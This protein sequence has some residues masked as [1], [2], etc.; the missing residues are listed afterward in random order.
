L[1][2]AATA[3]VFSLNSATPEP[4]IITATPP[5]T[6][7]PA[8]D[9]GVDGP[10]V[11]TATPPPVSTLAPLAT[12]DLPPNDAIARAQQALFNGNYTVAV[13]QYQA[14]LNQ[15]DT[16]L[17][18]SAWYG[19][20]QAALREGLFDQA[21]YAFTQFIET[22]PLEARIPQAYFQRGDAYLG[23]GNWPAAIADFELYLQLHPGIIDSYAYERMAD[24]Y[25]ALGWPDQAF[26]YYVQAANAPRNLEPMVA[27]RERIATAYL[28]QGFYAEAL[29][30][31]DS[32]LSV[33]Q[34]NGYRASIEYQAALIEFDLALANQ[35][36][37]RLN[38]IVTTYP[39]TAAAYQAMWVLLNNNLPVDNLLRAKISFANEDYGDV[40][41]ALN[42]YSAEVPVM[43]AEHLLTLGQAYRALGN[44]DAA[45]ITFQTIVD[46]YATS[47]MFGQALLEIGRTYFWQGDY[48]NA[49]NHYSSIATTYPDLPE[50]AEALWRVGFIYVNHFGDVDRA[51]GTYDILGK[52]YPGNEWAVDGLLSGA[53]LALNNDKLQQA[54]VFYTQ[55]ANTTVSGEEKALAFFWLARLYE[56]QGNIE[57]ATTTFQGASQADPGSYYSL[58][59]T[60]IL[61]GEA[62]FTPPTQ[63]RFSFDEG[64]VLA[65]AERW[66][67]ATF[68]IKQD[69][70]LYPLS[71]GLKA[72][73]HIIRG[74]ELWEVGAFDDARGEYAQL[75]E[76]YEADP[77]AIYQLAHY[78]S[79]KG[80]YRLSIEAAAQLI[81]ASGQN[82]FDV[83]SYIARLRYPV[84]YK[85]LVLT[86]SEQYN[87]DP[88]LIF[89]LIRQ[90]SLYQSFA[91]SFAYA[92]GLM[93]IIPDTG[94]W[95]AQ[96]LQWPNYQNSDLY[97]PYV[98]VAFGTFYLDWVLGVVDNYP[99][100]ALAGYNG[101]P[102]N[103]QH[104]LEIS[105]PDIDRFVQTIDFEETQLYVT[106]I[107]EQYNIY[108]H[109]YGLN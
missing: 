28:N 27:L 108:R 97:R 102:G 8:P 98:N 13:S 48:V 83:P 24:A 70:L 80:V 77:L 76:I 72:D 100:A 22:F 40:V 82:T 14:V 36:F 29:A 65:E 9:V 71:A 11:I 63:Y 31:Y 21:V 16:R 20:A 42:N 69:G 34:N 74:D 56:A 58:R 66:L 99:Y 61:A 39:E 54:Q 79:Q 68:A 15:S 104:W 1:G 86:Y 89:A 30:Q 88:L 64:T 49:I 12:P 35:A 46:Q 107:Y 33:A 105:G 3:C 92:Q 75:L 23:L 93:Q 59:A 38:R 37:G 57:L 26:H 52:T 73:A 91:T 106:R 85:D 17:H 4:I 95:V 47:P 19:L 84:Y 62:P 45:R 96:Q 60:D 43:S 87:L 25:L 51:L 7:Q 67:R 109:L 94:L 101:G 41:F 32:I 5:G 6:V 53:T 2:L 55:L 50:S 103:A 78:F 90:E 44:F 81:E 10:R 18:A